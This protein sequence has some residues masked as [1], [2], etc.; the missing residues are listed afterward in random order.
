MKELKSFAENF[1]AVFELED[2][3]AMIFMTA[4]TYIS[5]ILVSGILG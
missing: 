1:K 3:L 2:I 4:G 5:V